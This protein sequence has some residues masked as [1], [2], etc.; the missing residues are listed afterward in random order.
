MPAQCVRMLDCGK[1][2]NRKRKKL[3]LIVCYD[4]ITR[5]D[6]VMV[7]IHLVNVQSPLVFDPRIEIDVERIHCPYI[8]Y[9]QQLQLILRQVQLSTMRSQSVGLLVSLEDEACGVVAIS[10]SSL[11]SLLERLLIL[12]ASCETESLS[13]S[14]N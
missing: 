6:W 1:I 11:L 2:R 3:V 12:G 8:A 9:T 10:Y 4:V 14:S 13:A 5:A 7:S